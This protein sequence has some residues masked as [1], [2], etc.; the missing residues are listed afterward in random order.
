MSLRN[1][2]MQITQSSLG[3]STYWNL[4]GAGLP[5]AVGLL[6]I[7][8]LI[9]GMGA[10]AFGLLT[11][12]WAAI[13]YFSLFDFGLGRALTQ[14]VAAGRAQGATPA[15]ATLFTGALSTLLPGLLGMLLLGLLAEPLINDWLN[16]SPDLRPQAHAAM[17]IAALSIP[18]VTLSSGMRGILEG[19]EDFKSSALLRMMLGLLNFLVPWLLVSQG[20]TD[21]SW[22]VWGLLGS[23][24]LSLLVNL[25]MI[26]R[27]PRAGSSWHFDRQLLGQLLGFGSWMTLSNLI[28]PLMVT[29]DRYL[30]A[31]VLSA[32][33]VAFY[34]VPQDLVLRLLL[35]PTALVAALFPRLS[36]LHS[37]ANPAAFHQLY[38][39][40]VR[41]VGLSMGAL[42]VVLAVIAQPA[43][44]LWLG[45]DFAAA[46]WQLS[47]VLLLGIFFNSLAL[48]PLTA[49]HALRVVK[50]TSL[51]HL[52]ELL[53]YVPILWWL[54]HRFG[55]IGAAWAWT[56]RTGIDLLALHLLYQ[57]ERRGNT[58]A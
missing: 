21:L 16:I 57:H 2:L 26:L 41:L 58:A 22:L 4:L 29:A 46:S 20:I 5:L 28:G 10:E 3:K 52:M 24:L 12:I 34:T 1:S 25:P 32:Q 39:R 36:L 23:R 50:K 8:G 38:K 40:S 49:L 37:E 14:V 31:A 11:L 44:A 47:L 51:L 19:Y 33:V 9:D 42:L 43:L 15:G 27:H 17:R 35:V 6:V 18:L 55:L 7:P 13:G 53:L 48:L 54:L 56:F 45:A 30:I